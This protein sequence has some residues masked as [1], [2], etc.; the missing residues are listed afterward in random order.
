VVSRYCLRKNSINLKLIT[1][2]TGHTTV[3]SMWKTWKQIIY[4]NSWKTNTAQDTK[5]QYWTLWLL[6]RLIIQNFLTY[7]LEVTTIISRKTYQMSYSLQIYRFTV[8][9][10]IVQHDLRT[11]SKLRPHLQWKNNL[12]PKNHAAAACSDIDVIW[13]WYGCDMDVIWML[14]GGALTNVSKI[15]LSRNV[16]KLT[17]LVVIGTTRIYTK[18]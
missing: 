10:N 6:V 2:Q 9:H 18:F 11:L 17:Y 15:F 14:L 13:M 16:M 8:S 1:L 5:D 4:C 3:Y 12:P 7:S